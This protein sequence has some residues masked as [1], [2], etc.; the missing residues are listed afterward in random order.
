MMDSRLMTQHGEDRLAQV[1]LPHTPRLPQ[2][3]DRFDWGLF[4]EHLGPIADQ[5]GIGSGGLIGLGRIDPN[6]SN[7]TFSA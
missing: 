4:D 3:H 7:E 6:N 1:A 5:L 2:G